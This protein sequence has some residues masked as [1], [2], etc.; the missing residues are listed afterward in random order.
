MELYQAGEQQILLVVADHL[1]DELRS[2]LDR[3]LSSQFP[4]QT[5]Q[6]KLLD[7]NAYAAI[8][9]LM[10]A[11]I[12]NLNQERAR[13]LHRASDSDRQQV[14]AQ[15]RRL[16][17]ARARLLEGERKRSMAQLLSDGGFGSEAVAPLR[18]AV[19]STL[20]ALLVWQGQEAESPP[21]LGVIDSLLVQP[22][23]LPATTLSLVVQL[24]ET[25]AERDAGAL[26]RL[27][28][29]SDT[30]LTHSAALLQRD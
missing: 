3:Q 27:L 4:V 14:D 6:L 21:T 15:A 10:A 26:S 9:E 13:T 23:L 11:G 29:E 7:Q 24:R 12:L 17:Q 28:A 25:P 5:P 2:D 8:Q 19:D 16:T 30:L 22:G 20:Q 1:S 18:D